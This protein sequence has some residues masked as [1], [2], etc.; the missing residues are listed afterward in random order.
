MSEVVHF[1]GC[2]QLLFFFLV[3]LYKTGHQ[4][5]DWDISLL[6]PKANPLNR[7]YQLKDSGLYIALKKMLFVTYDVK[8]QTITLFILQP[9]P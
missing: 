7:V 3:N 2:N 8:E 9:S 4:Q 1:N 6:T 5:E